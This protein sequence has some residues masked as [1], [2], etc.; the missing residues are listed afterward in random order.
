MVLGHAFTR[1][2]QGPVLP[3]SSHPPLFPHTKENTNTNVTFHSE[4]VESTRG[5]GARVSSPSS[6]ARRVTRQRLPSPTT[7]RA[8]DSA[9]YAPPYHNPCAVAASPFSTASARTKSACMLMGPLRG[10]CKLCRSNI[11]GQ[12]RTLRRVPWN[13]RKYKGMIQM[14][15]YL[16]PGRA[17]M[18][19]MRY[20]PPPIPEDGGIRRE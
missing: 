12:P 3:P 6:M 13:T 19:T 4:D 2:R 17:G 20:F 14:V 16:P 9:Q 11:L 5:S 1:L 8:L 15:I 10:S 7:V 18:L